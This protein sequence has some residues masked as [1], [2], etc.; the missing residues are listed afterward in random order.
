[1]PGFGDL[2]QDDYQA[3]PAAVAPALLDFQRQMQDQGQ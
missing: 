1:M 2:A 3:P